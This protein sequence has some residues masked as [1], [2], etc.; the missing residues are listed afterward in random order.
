MWLRL[1]ASPGSTA[2]LCLCREQILDRKRREYRDMVPNYYDIQAVERSVED[3]TAL[4]QVLSCS[5][6]L[7]PVPNGSWQQ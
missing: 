1:G 4:R 7:C 6:K 2:L 5:L 3:D